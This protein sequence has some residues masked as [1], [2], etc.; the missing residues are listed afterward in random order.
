[1][2]EW[3]VLLLGLTAFYVVTALLNRALTPLARLAG[4]RL[5]PEGN[6]SRSNALPAPLRVLIVSLA[7][8]WLITALPLSLLVRQILQNVAIVATIVS[9]AWLLVLLGGV[10][11]RALT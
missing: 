2:S 7:T 11:E 6:A 10:V 3:L 9:V 5:F 4:R 1:L 8:R